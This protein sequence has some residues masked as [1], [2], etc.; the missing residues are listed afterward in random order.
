MDH[1]REWLKRYLETPLGDHRSFPTELADVPLGAVGAVGLTVRSSDLPSPVLVIRDD[2]LEHNIRLMADHCAAHGVSIAPHAKTTM[3]PLIIDRQVAA[4]AWG[5]TAATWR[6]AATLR[7]HGVRRVIIAN[8]LLDPRGI[9]WVAKTSVEDPEFDLYVLV[10]SVAGAGAMQEGLSAMGVPR[11]LNVL[12]EIGVEG[13]RAG[14]RTEEAARAVVREIQESPLLQ[15]AGIECFEGVL[16][17]P[18][19]VAHIA[20]D[21]LLERVVAVAETAEGMGAFQNVSEIILSAG[22]SVYFDRVIASFGRAGGRLDTPVRTVLRSG[23][24]VTHDSGVYDA[25]SPF[26]SRASGAVHLRAALE[27]WSTVVSRPEPGFAVLDFGKRDAPFDSGFPVVMRSCS[28]DGV[29]RP[30]DAETVVAMNDQHAVIELD[31]GSDLTVGDR[32]VLGISHPC[33]AFD[34]WRVLPLVDERGSVIAAIPTH[35]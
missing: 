34:R 7:A 1:R 12:L 16:S 4:G 14:V 15:L 27:L 30:R 2:A 13:K 5:M 33:T 17:G 32:V 25:L 23:C 26:G 19:D 28:D 6:Q 8:Q 11:P 20:V 3:A 31:A 29:E 24:Y 18:E 35:F 21:E 10:D 9:E 22:G